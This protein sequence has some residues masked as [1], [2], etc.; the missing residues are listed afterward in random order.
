MGLLV[1]FRQLWNCCYGRETHVIT[2]DNGAEHAVCTRCANAYSGPVRPLRADDVDGNANDARYLTNRALT[3]AVTGQMSADEVSG[4]EA[5][6]SMFACS[7]TGLRDCVDRDC[8]LHYTDAPVRACLKPRVYLE[9]PAMPIVDT[10]HADTGY[11]RQVADESGRDEFSAAHDAYMRDAYRAPTATL[12]AREPW[13]TVAVSTVPA[14]CPL[15]GEPLTGVRGQTYAEAG[16]LAMQATADASGPVTGHAPVLIFRITNPEG[17]PLADGHPSDVARLTMWATCDGW[18][19][20]LH[21]IRQMID[22]DATIRANP[23]DYLD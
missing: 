18:P 1:K 11:A 23:R 8:E 16:F 10:R 15:T 9:P 4:W 7:V 20:A 12:P 5:D 17:V 22:A 13:D 3:A 21:A 14:D 2:F 19:G 6:R